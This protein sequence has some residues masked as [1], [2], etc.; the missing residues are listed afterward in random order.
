M[1]QRILTMLTGLILA[2]LAVGCGA[3]ENVDFQ[4]I[5]KT[6]DGIHYNVALNPESLVDMTGTIR[7]EADFKNIYMDAASGVGVYLGENFA[8]ELQDHFAFAPITPYGFQ[9]KFL[10]ESVLVSLEGLSNQGLSEEELYQQGNQLILEKTADWM[11]VIRV[12]EKDASSAEVLNLA[13][14]FYSYSEEV[15]AVEDSVY[16]LLY[17]DELPADLEVTEGDKAFFEDSMPDEDFLKENL[18]FISLAQSGAQKPSNEPNLQSFTAEDMKGNTVT[19]DIF[20]DY[21]V[22]MVNIWA[23]WCGFCVE[24]MPQLQEL[25]QMLPENANMITIATDAADEFDLAD[26]ILTQSGAEFTTLIGNAE[27][28]ASLTGHVRGFPTTVFIDKDGKLVG[29]AI[30]GAPAKGDDIAPAYLEAINNALSE[31]GA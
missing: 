5:L 9:V 12:S 14:T 6:D 11:A 16:Y 31:I 20:K 18:I 25:Y 28:E 3:Q 17:N 15:A 19:Q 22:T 2:V 23:T 4:N 1:K 30:S 8:D 7:Y 24:E 10:P 27:L 26:A 21:D 13:K 29:K